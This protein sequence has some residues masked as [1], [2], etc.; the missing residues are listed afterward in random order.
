MG[1]GLGVRASGSQPV[2][3]D[4]WKRRVGETSREARGQEKGQVRVAPTI[5]GIGVICDMNTF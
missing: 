4:C 3:Q 2:F 1:S 5:I